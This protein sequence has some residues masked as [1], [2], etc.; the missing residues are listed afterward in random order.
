MTSTSAH[1]IFIRKENFDTSH[2]QIDKPFNEHIETVKQA[3]D[4]VIRNETLAIEKYQFIMSYKLNRRVKIREAGITIQIQFFW[5]GASP[6][7][8]IFEKKSRNWLIRD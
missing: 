2:K 6:D 8:V 4:H 7:G 1:K 5:L 3:L